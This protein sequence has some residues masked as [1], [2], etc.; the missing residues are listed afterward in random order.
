M[1][2]FT[3]LL[4]YPLTL[5]ALSPLPF[6]SLTLLSFI[7][8]YPTFLLSLN[9]AACPDFLSLYLFHFCIPFTL[10]FLLSCHAILCPNYPTPL[11]FC[12][13][14]LSLILFFLSL[15]FIFHPLYLSLYATLHP[16]S[17]TSGLTY[18]LSPLCFILPHPDYSS[19]SLSC[20][21]GIH[22]PTY[23]DPF[24]TSLCLPSS[25]SILP[26][27]HY[28]FVKHMVFSLF[29]SCVP[30]PFR[31]FLNITL[32]LLNPYFS[33]LYCRPLHSFPFL[34][35]TIHL[36][37]HSPFFILSPYVISFVTLCSLSLFI[38]QPKTVKVVA[39]MTV[40]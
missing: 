8:P 26:H 39:C 35:L 21:H 1:L 6:L 12:I 13:L 3:L 33:L 30:H 34:P 20:T 16:P 40:V 4:L 22:R 18:I 31:P 11:V 23:P 29:L 32:T 25:L 15:T 27:L 38:V 14:F 28:I 7:P 9:P 2:S 5:Y 36:L 19:P 24:C 10:R 37:S 17:P